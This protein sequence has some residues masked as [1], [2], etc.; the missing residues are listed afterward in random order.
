MKQ[1]FYIITT[2]LLHIILFSS[3]TIFSTDMYAQ[4]T[5]LPDSVP[6]AAPHRLFHIGLTYPLSTNGI[7]APNINNA[8]SF[9]A[10]IGISH[11]EE[12][13]SMAGVGNIING[14][15]TGVCASGVINVIKGPSKGLVAAG[16]I[17]QN[18]G[19]VK[20]I[21]VAG[22]LNNASNV[23]GVQ[24]AGV[25]NNAKTS[26]VQIAGI[27]NLANQSS[28][29]ISGL[30][31]QANNNAAQLGGLINI[32]K[33]SKVQISGF[34]NVSKKT[35]GLQLAGLINIAEEADYPIGIINII[36]N[37]T[38]S[39]GISMDEIG[40]TVLA[41]R[42]GG[43]K[44]YG[45]LG[46]GQNFFLPSANHVLEVGWGYRKQLNNYWSMQYEIANTANTDFWKTAYYK[47]SFRILLGLHI[48]NIHIFAGPTFNYI[49][50]IKGLAA[51]SNYAIYEFYG[52]QSI[53][54]LTIGGIGGLAIQF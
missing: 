24:I 17:N 2:G 6:A 20:G 49:N 41:F 15:Q 9:H 33:Q 39:I 12:S 38:K 18:S 16:V 5:D 32:A 43:T 8:I 13:L 42:S 31:N 34:I 29:Q 35:K 1:L 53:N 21:Q 37:G 14:K 54:S 47:S 28:T 36:K 27:A 11:N 3:M 52:A 26:N 19:A 22:V 10:L 50:N 25:M 40:N 46:I 44:T 4:S 23:Q 30:L 48:K 45:I 51:Y 7:Q